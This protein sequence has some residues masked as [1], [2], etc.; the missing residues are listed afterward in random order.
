M[1]RGKLAANNSQA[2]VLPMNWKFWAGVV[3]CAAIPAYLADRLVPGG[4]LTG[5]AA[6]IGGIVGFLV[7]RRKGSG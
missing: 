1:Q 4:P 5:W 7:S 3:L 2:G 6:I